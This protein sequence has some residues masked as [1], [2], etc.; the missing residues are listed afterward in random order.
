MTVQLDSSPLAQLIIPVETTDDTAISGSDYTALSSQTVT[1]AA[2]AAGANLSQTV[3]ITILE[4]SLDEADETFKVSFGTLPGGVTAGTDN[5]VTVTITDDDVPEV[6]FS[7]AAATVA[8]GDGTI[9]V[10]VQ[11]DSSPLAQLIIP[12]ET[13]DDTAISGSDYTALSSQTVTFAAG[14]AGANL[15]QTVTITILEDS[16]DEANETF[17]VSFGTLPGGVTAGTDNEVTVT[18][19]DDDVPE[20]TFSSAAATVAEGDGTIE[21][22]V[23]LDSSPLAQLIIPVETTDDTAISGSD[24]TALSSQT[25]TFCR[26]RGRCQ[27]EPDGDDHDS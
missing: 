1:F 18:I 24:Y 23:Q 2:G 16:L 10:T 27:L 7:S 4:D 17:T 3:T 19:T 21:V 26:G 8:E 14:A 25:V 5:E 6:T 13:T 15:S 9:E 11:L 12:V 20:V 22:T